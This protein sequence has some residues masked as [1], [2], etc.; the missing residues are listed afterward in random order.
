MGDDVEVRGDQGG[1]PMSYGRVLRW[2][3]AASVRLLGKRSLG[4]KKT[5]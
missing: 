2:I 3:I 5:T 4:R 1:Q